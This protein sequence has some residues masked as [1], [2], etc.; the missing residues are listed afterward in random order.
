MTTKKGFK[1]IGIDISHWNRV[2]DFDKVR[3]SGVSFAIIK[4]GGSDK[5][6]YKDHQFDN[7][8]RLAKNAGLKVGAYYFVG[9]SFLSARDGIEDAKRFMSIIR[10]KE[11]DYPVFLDLETT[12]P[13]AK[14]NATIASVAFLEELESNGYFAGI[15]ASDISG[16]K[17]R[18][19]L[20]S[21]KPFAKWVAK[22]SSKKP[23]YVKDYGI[24]QYSSRGTID[25]IIGP[26]DLDTSVVDYA[27]IIRA[28]NFNRG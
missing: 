20:K 8:Y 21:L 22:Y 13:A 16:Y 15:Y 10:G 27:A 18:L 9:P 12:P 28:K 26:V 1:E 2:T 6:F 11:F 4:A 3:A 5:G 19:I 14:E 7:Y 24:W 25:G 17:E 23:E